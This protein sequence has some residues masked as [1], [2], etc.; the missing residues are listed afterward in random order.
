MKTT[1]VPSTE[2]NKYFFLGIL[3]NGILLTSIQAI[4]KEFGFSSK[5][6]GLIVSGNDMSSIMI[7]GVVSFFGAKKNKPLWME[8]EQLLLVSSY[9]LDDLIITG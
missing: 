2:A 9:A 5:M 8:Q 7:V 1:T 3:V 4:E 6:T